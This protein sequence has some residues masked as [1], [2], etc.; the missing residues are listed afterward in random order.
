MPSLLNSE[1]GDAI[2]RLK[3]LHTRLVGEYERYI[4]HVRIF[5]GERDA[6]NLNS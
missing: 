3:L 1:P 6:H 5:S 2:S 4:K